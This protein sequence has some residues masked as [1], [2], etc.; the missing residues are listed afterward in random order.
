MVTVSSVDPHSSGDKV[1]RPKQPR[2]TTQVVMGSNIAQIMTQTLLP[3]TRRRVN[4]N[5]NVTQ[6]TELT[7]HL[8]PLGP[9]SGRAPKNVMI[10]SQRPKTSGTG[11][12]FTTL[13][14][15]NSTVDN[16]VQRQEA[17]QSSQGRAKI[18]STL[19]VSSDY[20]P[21]PAILRNR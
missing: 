21:Q 16:S 10:K 6:S 15:L 7:S 4:R 18:G 1:R 3:Y 11:V 12:Q 19:T 8:K 14:T 5:E 9:A 17:I 20:R 2:P 13:Q